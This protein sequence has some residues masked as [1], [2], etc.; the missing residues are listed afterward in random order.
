MLACTDVVV[1]DPPIPPVDDDDEEDADC[2]LRF[3]LRLDLDLGDSGEVLLL[4]EALHPAELD[5]EANA[6]ANADAGLV[7]ALA[8]LAY[9]SS[10]VNVDVDVVAFEEDVLEAPIL[11]L[12]CFAI[13]YYMYRWTS[14]EC[15][16]VGCGRGCNICRCGW[17]TTSINTCN[18]Y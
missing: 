10:A 8:A 5:A 14:V 12:F 16:A 4:L 2:L 9:T 1:N 11:V 3:C 7:L 6:D 13:S 17:Y 18:L 15:R